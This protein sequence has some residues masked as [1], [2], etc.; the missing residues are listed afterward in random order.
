VEKMVLS[1][2]LAGLRFGLVRDIYVTGN[3]NCGLPLEEVEKCVLVAFNDFV[4][5]ATNGNKTRGRM[6]NALQT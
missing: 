6:K 2:M 5:N 4:D 3:Q 1:G